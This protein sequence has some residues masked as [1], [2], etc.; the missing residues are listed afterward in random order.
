[1]SNHLLLEFLVCA[2]M[3]TALSAFHL[4]G[5]LSLTL[6]TRYHIEH[7]RTGSVKLDR[8]MTPMTMILGLFILHGAQVWAYALLFIGL[9]GMGLEPA[10]FISTSAYT[11]AGLERFPEIRD[12]RLV[13]GNESLVGFLL[14]GWST[15]FLFTNL[16]RIMNTEETH[17]LPAGAIAKLED[18]DEDEAMSQER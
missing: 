9:T 18:E 1:M 17:P 11:T 6:L 14:I 8:L 5:L 4:T 3:T 10:L 2:A 13:V 15:A 12:W 16:Q 7:W